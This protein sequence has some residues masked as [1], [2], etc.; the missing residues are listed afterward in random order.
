MNLPQILFLDIETVPQFPTYNDCPD[1][2]KAL[3]EHKALHLKKAETETAGDIYSRAGIYAEF[4]RIICISTGFISTNNGV[5]ELRVKSFF[6]HD[7]KIVLTKFSDLLNKS[8]ATSDCKLCAHNGREFDFPYIARRMVINKVQLPVLLDT[9]GKKPWEV[10]HLDTMEMW[11]FGDFKSY[12]PLTLLAYSLGIP[13]PKDD[14]DGSMVW[15]VYWK[16]NDLNRIVT[17]CEKDVEALTNVYLRMKGKEIIRRENILK[18][19]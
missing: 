9:A 19:K 12:T 18:I 6:G 3:W 16:D 1:E 13:S 4:G 2:L 8:F 10:N 15:S 17:Y 5:N 14:I 7:E 11:K